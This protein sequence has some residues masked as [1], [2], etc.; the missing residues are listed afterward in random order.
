MRHIFYTLML[1]VL[2]GCT[3]QSKPVVKK[4]HPPKTVDTSSADADDE[5]KI[6]YSDQQL[7]S[8][9]DSVGKLPTQ[10]LADKVAF[11]AD[12]VFKDQMALD[13]MISSKDFEI[14]K[15]A[16]HK[17]VMHV[18]T[19]T[20]IFGNKHIS[21]DC[22]TKSVLLNYKKGFIPVVYYP[23]DKD[24]TQFNEYAV[25]IGD[26]G[27]CLSAAL[28]F[29]KGNRIIALHDG[30]N[31]FAPDLEHYKDA[32][33]KTVI[34]YGKGFDSGSGIWWNN[35]FFY[36]YD[37]N[38]LIPILDELQ[39]G[40]RQN[41]F[42]GPRVMWLEST[43]IKTDPLTIKMVYYQYLSSTNPYYK[44]DNRDADP[45]IID[46]S[47]SVQYTWN[48]QA[49]TLDGQY[50]SSKISKPQIL[51]YY[52][53]DNELLFVNAYYKTLKH[54]LLNKTKRKAV[55]NYLNEIKNHYSKKGS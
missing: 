5:K 35:F 19:A 55:L 17:G 9:L 54:A 34:Y 23:F 29:F 12:S 28:Y 36:K 3:H 48:E 14:I 38:K 52:L 42:W 6:H 39:N 33:G 16:A 41:F 50:K 2:V 24:T 7:E 27:H 25:C 30:Y 11:G 53:Q 21:Y 44:S 49:K 8:F 20:R 40:N 10:R 43:V 22:T 32:D 26:P 31:R 18:K 47:T 37:G 51:S 1:C 45:K 46:D 4:V 13:T 15:R